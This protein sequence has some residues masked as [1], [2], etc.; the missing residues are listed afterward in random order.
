MSEGNQ[1]E[2]TLA[3]NGGDCD[4]GESS[5][6]LLNAVTVDGFSD[7]RGRPIL[8]S[9]SGGWRSAIFI[10]VVELSERFA[11]YGVSLNLMSYLTGPLGQSKAT[12]AQKVNTWT[13]VA[14]LMSLLGA[15]IADC[16]LGRYQTIILAS[17]LYV[18][19]LGLLTLSAELSST[20]QSQVI[21]F[22]S[23][24]YLIAFAEGGHKPCVQAFGAEQFDER[25]SNEC[26]AKSSFFNWWSFGIC[27]SIS[28]AVVV[29]SYVQEDLSWA[30]GF[31][32]PCIFMVFA[33]LIF[34][35]GTTTYRY[36]VKDSYNNPFLRIGRVYA[37]A[38]RNWR[39]S[40]LAISSE[41]EA[42]GSEQSK[43][44]QK[45]CQVADVADAKALLRLAPI[46][47]SCLVYTIVFAQTSTFFTEQGKTVDRTIWPGFDLPAASFQVFISL[48]IALFIPI[49]DRIFVPIARTLTGYPSGITTIQRIGSGI[50]ITIIT[51]VVAALVEAK[52]LKI[53]SEYGLVDSPEAT[54]PMSVYWLVPQYILCGITDVFVI[55]GLQELFYDEVA[56]DLRSLGQALCLSVTGVANFFSVF[57]IYMIK[58]VTG[59]N[60][61]WVCDNLNRAHLDYYYWLLAGLSFVGL[62]FYICSAKS[63]MYRPSSSKYQHEM[64]SG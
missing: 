43:F 47:L 59:S 17:A 42:E 4:G 28:I 23:S 6:P 37:R 54:V 18:L 27:S 30:L 2:M 50:F 14:S 58:K 61:G 46:W 1:P 11:F 48:T 38:A 39:R 64:L 60:D 16:F 55:I 40:V 25:D 36:F 24:L 51:M 3:V 49:Y 45:T 20:P 9:D 21:L 31:G 15:F 52:R 19:A 41:G 10:I 26:R 22:F 33:L 7:Y 57:L 34:L 5:S 12:A 44:L 53:A 13:G 63:Y 8:R 29:L 56:S 32:I 35:S 62:V